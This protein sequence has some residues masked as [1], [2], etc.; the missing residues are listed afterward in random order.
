MN[1]DSPVTSIGPSLQNQQLKIDSC[2]ESDLTSQVNF[3]NGHSWADAGF[4]PFS[5]FPLLYNQS[6]KH[7]LSS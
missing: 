1:E 2:G 6:E 4:Q 5:P 7:S 3:I